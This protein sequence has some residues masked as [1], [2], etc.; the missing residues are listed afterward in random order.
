[1]GL[2]VRRRQIPDR[3]SDKKNYRSDFRC[4]AF[5]GHER[6]D[7]LPMPCHLGQPETSAAAREKSKPAG[8]HLSGAEGLVSNLDPPASASKSASTS[9]RQHARRYSIGQSDGQIEG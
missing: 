5:A 9:F 2:L 4:D 8:R 6:A 1:M 3:A 7:V